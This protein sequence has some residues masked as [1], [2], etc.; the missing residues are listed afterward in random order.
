MAH[1]K[2]DACFTNYWLCIWSII[3]SI[4]SQS[5]SIGLLWS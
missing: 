1:P 2:T 4:I 3:S 5:I